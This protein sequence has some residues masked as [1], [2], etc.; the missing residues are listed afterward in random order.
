VSGFDHL[1]YINGNDKG[2]Q[3]L[4]YD[5]RLLMVGDARIYYV[6]RSCDYWVTFSRSPFAEAAEAAG[7]RADRVMDWLGRQGYTHVYVDFG[8]IQRL[9]DTSGFASG[10]DEALFNR[11]EGAGLRRLHEAQL[12]ANQPPYGVL[13]E[14][15]Q[16]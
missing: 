9:R 2:Q 3:G 10:I 7:G 16:S 6:G 5:A 14:V 12:G 15:P 11:L 4:P 1:Q 8:E 13:Y